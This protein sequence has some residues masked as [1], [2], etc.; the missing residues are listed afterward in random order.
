M[1]YIFL[2]LEIVG[3]IEQLIIIHKKLVKYN[4]VKISK[5]SDND[6]NAQEQQLN[7]IEKFI[8]QFLGISL[9]SDAKET[10]DIG[11]KLFI[12]I[13]ER[14]I[15]TDDCDTIIHIC[16]KSNDSTLIERLLNI[17]HKFK[18]HELL[19]R[20]NQN[21]ETCLHVACEM[22]KANELHK[23]IECGA[24]P[25]V[26]DLNSNTPL[27]IA[28]L[29]NA[30]DAAEYLIQKKCIN[31]F[32]TNRSGRTALCLAR[33]ANAVHLIQLMEQSAAVENEHLSDDASNIDDDDVSSVNSRVSQ[34]TNDVS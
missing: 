5:D 7:E 14:A 8:K 9:F 3:D 10:F 30:F 13:F 33:I 4:E 34:G 32:D 26:T 21:Q 29:A 19:N 2:A 23:L 12:Y 28:I 15:F 18:L 11:R 16:V 6:E 27:H 24:N 1:F 25:N 31:P 17:L 20:P 22:N